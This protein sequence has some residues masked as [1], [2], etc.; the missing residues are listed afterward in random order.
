MTWKFYT[1]SLILATTLQD[2]LN[3]SL[4]T[5]VTS[6]SHSINLSVE[7]GLSGSDTVAHTCNPSSLRDW[8]EHITWGQEFETSLVNMVNPVSTKNTKISQVWWH[9]PAWEAEAGK[10]PESRRRRLQWAK[11]MPLHSILGERVRLR[12]G[13]DRTGQDRKGQDRKRKEK[14]KTHLEV[15][16]VSTR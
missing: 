7:V 8:G 11:F 14:E 10:P 9:V 2:W 6:L 4:T 16:T 1:L 15:V 5:S 13:Q 3:Q 12:I